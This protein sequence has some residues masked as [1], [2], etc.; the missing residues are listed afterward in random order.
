MLAEALS[1]NFV[2]QLISYSYINLLYYWPPSLHV[3]VAVDI[4]IQLY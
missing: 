2:K 4:V 3:F 1:I